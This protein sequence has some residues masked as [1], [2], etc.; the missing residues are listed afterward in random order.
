MD[1]VYREWLKDVVENRWC[2]AV[3]VYTDEYGERMVLQAIYYLMNNNLWDVYEG[4]LA[5]DAREDNY[6]DKLDDMPSAI[7]IIKESIEE[8]VQE[9]PKTQNDSI[10]LTPVPSWMQMGQ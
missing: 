8:Q 4:K 7:E 3:N 2:D 1:V 6:Y 9:E 5:L 10:P